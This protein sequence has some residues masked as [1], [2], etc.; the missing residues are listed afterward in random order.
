[1][2]GFVNTWRDKVMTL[3]PKRFFAK[4]WNILYSKR[5]G[6]S[7]VDLVVQKKPASETVD[8]IPTSSDD[9]STARRLLFMVWHSFSELSIAA[10]TPLYCAIMPT[11]PEHAM[12]TGSLNLK[13]DISHQERVERLA[14]RLVRGLRHVLYKK[15]L[16]HFKFFSLDSRRLQCW[17]YPWSE[18]IWFRRL[19]TPTSSHLRNRLLARTCMSF[20]GPV[21]EKHLD[22]QW[23]IMF[24]KIQFT[25]VMNLNCSFVLIVNPGCLCFFSPLSDHRFTCVY[26]VFAGAVG[27][28]YKVTSVMLN[29]SML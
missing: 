18:P 28:S 10:F 9:A 17:P 7:G 11:R 16:C 13:T 3:K 6:R 26:T 24:P 29:M 23:D 21:F 4:W 8:T 20:T 25:Y 1:M 2:S 14:T 27:Q 22:H 15:R 5:L 12:E 19:P